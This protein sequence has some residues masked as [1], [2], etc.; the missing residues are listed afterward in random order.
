M[1]DNK[2]ASCCLPCL[3]VV[4]FTEKILNCVCCCPCRVVNNLKIN[5]VPIS[6]KDSERYSGQIWG[7]RR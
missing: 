5:P 2:L 4:L 6:K 1:S 7:I 3:A